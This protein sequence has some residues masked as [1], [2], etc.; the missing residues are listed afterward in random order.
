MFVFLNLFLFFFLFISNENQITLFA[1]SDHKNKL[2][3]STLKTN[4]TFFFHFFQ[5]LFFVR[6]ISS[7]MIRS[8]LMVASYHRMTATRLANRRHSLATLEYLPYRSI[9]SYKMDADSNQL[10]EALK[11]CFRNETV[12]EIINLHG[13]LSQRL[14]SGC[15]PNKSYDQLDSKGDHSNFKKSNDFVDSIP[16]SF[17]FKRFYV[18]ALSK[19]NLC[20][21]NQKVR[22]YFY[23]GFASNKCISTF[24]FFLFLT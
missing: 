5:F 7:K 21:L 24:F 2:N 6:A 22:F 16:F 4:P 9:S 19:L 11:N 23:L 20:N 3:P 13:K 10:M 12:N 8:T 17:R 14:N 1:F 15:E 18:Q